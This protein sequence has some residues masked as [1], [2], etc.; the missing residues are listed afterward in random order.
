[1]GSNVDIYE[2]W[3]AEIDGERPTVDIC[4]QTLQKS[5]TPN[6]GAFDGRCYGAMLFVSLTVALIGMRMLRK[7]SGK[8]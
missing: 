1:M 5:E 6:T 7:R 8:R 2:D 4:E 3:I